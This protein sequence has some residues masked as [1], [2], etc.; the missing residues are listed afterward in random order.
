MWKIFG[1]NYLKK[2][3]THQ[4]RYIIVGVISLFLPFY[5]CSCIILFLVLRL[6]WS[7][8]IQNAYHRSKVNRML[9]IFCFLSMFISFI[10]KN[11][12]GIFVAFFL[13]IAG[14]FILY[15]KA[16]ISEDL[17]NL[18]I[19]LILILSLFAAFYGLIEY[20]AILNSINIDQFEIIIFNKPKE[21]INS[22]FFNANYYATMIEFFVCLAFYNILKL[23]NLKKDFKKLLYYTFIIL[24]NF[25]HFFW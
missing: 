16:H 9:F 10:Y 20:I 13:L 18:I 11:Y 19:N 25:L 22:V 2:H 12:V 23:K 17:F 5:I 6:I 3:F 14:L 1:I 4:Q 8:E 24:I 7:G 21:R 15:Y